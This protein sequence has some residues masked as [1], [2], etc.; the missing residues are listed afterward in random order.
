MGAPRHGVAA[1]AAAEAD[2]RRMVRLQDMS[3]PELRNALAGDRGEAFLWMQS[4]AKCGAPT[5]QLRLGQM[6]LDGEGTPGDEARALSWFLKAAGQGLPEA[7]NMAGRCYENGWGTAVDLA[8]AAQ[9]YGA[10]AD[11]GHDWGQYNFAHMLFD[12]RGVA[13]DQPQALVWYLR[14]AAQGHARAMNLAARCFEE[15]WGTP[16]D[17]AR[18]AELYRSSAKAG[19]FRAQFNFATVLTAQ[20]RVEDALPWFEAACRSATPD[21]LQ[22]MVEALARHPEARLRAL[23]ASLKRDLQTA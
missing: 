22:V 17:P 5:A 20:G 16:R 6:L 7:M 11:A 21:S 13:Q 12:G 10:S 15:G 23:G 9:W 1:A 19:Y 4:A 2:Y 3:G 14:A 18:A 8:R